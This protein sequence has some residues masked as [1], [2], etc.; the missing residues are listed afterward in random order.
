[1]SRLLDFY[2]TQLRVLWEWRGGPVALL[3][4][5]VITLVVATVSF[6][7][8]AW[9]MP[10]LTVDRPL[11][12]AFAVIL[13]ALFNA[14]IRPVVLTFAASISLVLTGILVLV[15]QI[16]AFLVVAQWAPGIHVD[17]F[18]TALIASFVYA[19]FNTILTAILAGPR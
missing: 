18:A 17:G 6:L 9:I 11:D 4:R 13:M 7:L 15:L 8:T 12:A 16:V 10:R 2:A 1:M 19:I 14:A 3:K 5:L